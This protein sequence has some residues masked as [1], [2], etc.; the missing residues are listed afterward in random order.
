MTV[1]HRRPTKGVAMDPSSDKNIHMKNSEQFAIASA[2]TSLIFCY[3]IGDMFSVNDTLV[4][5]LFTVDA[6]STLIIKN[7]K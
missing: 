1:D 6:I 4:A 3:Q 5:K 2:S 7:L